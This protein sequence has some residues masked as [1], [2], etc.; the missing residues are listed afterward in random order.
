MD[1]SETTNTTDLYADGAAAARKEVADR[2]AP[3]RFV[4]A[5]IARTRQAVLNNLQRNDKPGFVDGYHNE[6]I[7]IAFDLSI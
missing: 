7:R 2:I 6:M 3:A 5:E 4:K 1:M